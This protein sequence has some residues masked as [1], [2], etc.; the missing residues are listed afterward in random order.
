MTIASR[1][2][3]DWSRVNWLGPDQ[4]II[5]DGEDLERCSYC[6]DEIPDDRVP[7]RI[8]DELGWGAV[9]CGHCE[10]A[11]WGLQSFDDQV[12]PRDEAEVR[13]RRERGG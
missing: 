6:G 1:P 2:G 9:F 7:L 11:C 4:P 13:R 10:A 8:W 5:A 3:F 12:E